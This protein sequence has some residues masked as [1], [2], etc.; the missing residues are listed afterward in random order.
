MSNESIGPEISQWF[1]PVLRC[2]VSIIQWE[3][4]TENQSSF[5]DCLLREL[6]AG[7]AQ[8]QVAVT[9]E[10]K[11]RKGVVL[12]LSQCTP[13]S[14]EGPDGKQTSKPSDVCGAM[15]NL[16]EPPL[17]H[18]CRGNF[19]LDFSNLP[20][21][22]PPEQ[23]PNDLQVEIRQTRAGD[24]DTQ[25]Q[26]A[27]G[28]SVQEWDFDPDVCSCCCPS[29][30]NTASQEGLKRSGEQRKE[31]LYCKSPWFYKTSVFLQHSS[32]ATNR[33]FMATYSLMN[34]LCDLGQV[35]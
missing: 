34:L 23:G 6:A 12:R 29:S 10:G 3:K 31:S 20:T 18:C 14:L 26:A 35:T 4:K 33:K 27:T 25:A 8:T 17:L 2:D 24:G 30:T 19:S 13:R 16:R 11:R 15:D 32:A 22:S 9:G 1:L 21:L 5:P 28:L 7:G